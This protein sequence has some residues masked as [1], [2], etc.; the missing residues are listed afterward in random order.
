MDYRWL[1]L[2]VFLN[3]IGC[4]AKDSIESSLSSKEQRRTNDDLDVNSMCQLISQL[5]LVETELALIRRLSGKQYHISMKR[6][7][8]WN[9]SGC[10]I[11]V[12]LNQVGH[13]ES[14]SYFCSSFKPPANIEQIYTKSKTLSDFTDRL[15]EP[16]LKI[17][18]RNYQIAFEQGDYQMT[19]ESDS[20]GNIIS[21]STIGMTLCPGG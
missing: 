8:S 4:D 2:G 19:F 15:G 3:L 20:S 10:E 13:I 14:K 6:G 16:E 7:Y 18:G 5:T 21:R 12:D 11:T 1:C 17:V 9:D